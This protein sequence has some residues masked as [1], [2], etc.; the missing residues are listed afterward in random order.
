MYKYTPW[1]GRSSIA[2]PHPQSF[3]LM[4]SAKQRLWYDSAGDRTPNLRAD[5]NYKDTEI[6]Q[7]EHRAEL[8]TVLCV[9][10]ET[11]TQ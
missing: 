8:M 7:N 3:S 6:V 5:T 10:E 1:T 2:G 9:G 11:D 4:L